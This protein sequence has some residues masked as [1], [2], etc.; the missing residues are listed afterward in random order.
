M[1]KPRKNETKEEFMNRCVPIVIKEGK[2]KDQAIAICNSL[3]KN[4]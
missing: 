1:P 3:Y 2:K 4:K